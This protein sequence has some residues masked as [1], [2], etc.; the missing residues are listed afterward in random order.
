M[1]NELKNME[2]DYFYGHCPQCGHVEKIWVNLLSPHEQ[3]H[4]CTHCYAT[5]PI[6]AFERACEHLSYGP[7]G[8]SALFG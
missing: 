4:Q 1:A 6:W 3:K 7:R 8:L 2:Q 5:R